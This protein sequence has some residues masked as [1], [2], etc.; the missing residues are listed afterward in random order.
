[1]NVRTDFC[2]PLL[3]FEEKYEDGDS[4]DPGDRVMTYTCYLFVM[5]LVSVPF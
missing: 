4:V 5:G 3:R 1:M 2:G